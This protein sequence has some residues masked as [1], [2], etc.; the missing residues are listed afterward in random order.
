MFRWEDE[1][2]KQSTKQQAKAVTDYIDPHNLL[3]S[4]LFS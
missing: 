4:T 3:F 1:D 2:I